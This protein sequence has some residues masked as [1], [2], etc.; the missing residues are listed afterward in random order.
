MKNWLYGIVVVI[1]VAMIYVGITKEG[2]QASDQVLPPKNGLESAGSQVKTATTAPVTVGQ[3][4]Q[5]FRPDVA[6]V[7]EADKSQLSPAETAERDFQLTPALIAKMYL[8][9]KYKFGI[10]Y[11]APASVPQAAI[12]SLVNSNPPLSNFLKQKYSLQTDLEIYNKQKQLQ[13]ITLAETSSS[14]F[15][16]SFTDG[17]CQNTTYYQGVIQVSGVTVSETNTTQASH[18][19]Q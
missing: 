13:A 8:I 10:C 12:T 14:K 2:N 6:P 17:Q 16:F 15:N 9:D 18:T 4:A 3:V 11:G 5:R 1:C 7:A 19:Y